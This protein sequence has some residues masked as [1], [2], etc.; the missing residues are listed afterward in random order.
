MHITQTFYLFF[1]GTLVVKQRL[2]SY[3]SSCNGRDIKWRRRG[4]GNLNMT[5]DAEAEEDGL[6]RGRRRGV[7]HLLPRHGALARHEP[8]GAGMRRYQL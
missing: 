6:P 7:L 3:L 8:D 5:C 4:E 2:T 1:I